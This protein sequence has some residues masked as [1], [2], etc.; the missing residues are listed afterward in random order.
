MELLRD[1]GMPG[2]LSDKL[3]LILNNIPSNLEADENSSDY[4]VNLMT[5]KHQEFRAINAY[6]D[7]SIPHHIRRLIALQS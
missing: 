4:D 7:S 6:T 3:E 5:R 2:D 1:R